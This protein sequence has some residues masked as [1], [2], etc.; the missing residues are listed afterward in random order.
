MWIPCNPGL[1]PF[2]CSF[3]DNGW[4]PSF[5]ATWHL[6]KQW[7]WFSPLWKA[8]GKKKKQLT[9]FKS[10]SRPM[11]LFETLSTWYATLTLS[12]G[13]TSTEFNTLMTSFLLRKQT[14]AK[15]VDE[16]SPLTLKRQSSLS[17]GVE[18]EQFQHTARYNRHPKVHISHL[19]VQLNTHRQIST[20]QTEQPHR[21]S[22]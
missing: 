16:I 1:I 20:S 2:L 12:N 4:L 9:L 5:P 10:E 21:H 14:L 19:S 7:Y 17:P 15:K 22:K 3:Q 13:E 6:D 11:F 18:F 8:E